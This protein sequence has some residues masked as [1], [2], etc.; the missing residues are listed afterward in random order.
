M[1]TEST[2]TGVKTLRVLIDGL[3]YEYA[4][5]Y[6][7]H[8]DWQVRRRLRT[9]LGYS[10][11]AIPSLLTGL[12]PEEHGAW[13]LFMRSP[14]TSPF[15]WARRLNR[16]P[17]ERIPKLRWKYRSW[18]DNQVRARSGIT[19]YF[20]LYDIPHRHRHEFDV[21]WR[22]NLFY[23]GGMPGRSWLHCWPLGG[24]TASYIG[25][26]PRTDEQI[27]QEA[28][29]AAGNGAG[30]I[31]CYFGRIDG[32]L[33]ARAHLEDTR[34]DRLGDSLRLY[35][36]FVRDLMARMANDGS[37]VE[38]SIFSDHGMTPVQE[39]VDLSHVTRGLRLGKEYMAFHDATFAR[40]WFENDLSRER[41]RHALNETTGGRLLNDDDL[42]GLPN[43]P[44]KYGQLVWLAEPGVVL[45]PNWMGG[46]PKGMHGY[47]P[48]DRWSD[49][50][51]LS[52]H[53]LEASD[54]VE[55]GQEFLRIDTE[56]EAAGDQ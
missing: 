15:G 46:T 7:L 37:R 22:K 55:L 31:F 19:G 50:V 44:E 10:S 38:V 6:E 39:C 13:Q 34:D 48:S 18:L 23:D 42:V 33:H 52:N 2:P 11:T 47:D 24:Q 14:E 1:A 17:W 41:V 28:M 25:A 49:G 35:E 4:H 8:A 56:R 53:D 3:G 9:V 51:L 12:T 29:V 21:N 5:M 45:E 54:V 16:F 27:M 36:H 32:E 43:N 30:K 20:A 26:Y 40:Y